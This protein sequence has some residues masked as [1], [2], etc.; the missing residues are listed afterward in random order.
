MPWAQTWDLL[1]KRSGVPGIHFEDHEQL[2]G[3]EL[4]E[5]SHL[6]GPEADWFTAQLVPLVEHEFAQQ[7]MKSS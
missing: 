4:P 1:I 7:A 2:P 6:S 3:Y 5:W